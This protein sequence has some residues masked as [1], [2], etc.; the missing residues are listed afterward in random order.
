MRTFD[1]LKPEIQDRLKKFEVFLKEHKLPKTR[2]VFFHTQLKYVGIDTPCC[3]AGA[4]I[5][6]TTFDVPT[7]KTADFL[8]QIAPT[9]LAVNLRLV[10]GKIYTFNDTHPEMSHLEML[11]FIIKHPEDFFSKSAFKGEA[12]EEIL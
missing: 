9:E 8:R 2:G 11:D 4:Y 10:P 6:S 1:D 3:F 5:L 7:S 12:Y